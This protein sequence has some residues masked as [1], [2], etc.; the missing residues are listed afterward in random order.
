MTETPSNQGNKG[1]QRALE[2]STHFLKK[3]L[4]DVRECKVLAAI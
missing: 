3:T 4:Q 2:K 1:M